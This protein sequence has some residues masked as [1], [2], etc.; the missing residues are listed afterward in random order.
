[1]LLERGI[2]LKRWERQASAP[3]HTSS[4]WGSRGA[5]GVN[6]GG[7]NAGEWCEEDG[8]LG[9]VE[10]RGCVGVEKGERCGVWRGGWGG[11]V[12]TG[13][14]EGCWQGESLGEGGGVGAIH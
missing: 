13:R 11:V 2:Q 6:G 10:R 4:R 5:K 3:A 12:R 9:G 14:G 8:S 1:M 7:G